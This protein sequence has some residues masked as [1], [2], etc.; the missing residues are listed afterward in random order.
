[1][2]AEIMGNVGFVSNK[3]ISWRYISG[4][5]KPPGVKASSEISVKPKD[6]RNS[7]EINPVGNKHDLSKLKEVRNEIREI[8]LHVIGKNISPN[9]V[10]SKVLTDGVAINSAFFILENPMPTKIDD[11]K[12]YIKDLAINVATN[13]LL[14]L[15]LLGI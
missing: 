3:S 15:V 11:L 14:H 5:E 12:Q 8:E 2:P 10:F 4:F 13:V 1:M 9:A 6:K 7:D